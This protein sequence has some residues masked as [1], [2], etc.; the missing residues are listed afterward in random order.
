MNFFSKINADY[1]ITLFFLL[2]TANANILSSSTVGWFAIMGMMFIVAISRKQ[3]TRQDFANIAIFSVVYLA[4][5]FFRFFAVNELETDYLTSDV[6]FLFKYVFLAFIVT[7]LLKERALANIVRVTTHLTVLSFVFFLFQVLAGETMFRLFSA[8]NFPT[9]NDIPGYTNVLFFTYT[10]G[11]HDFSNS[12]FV[13]EPGSFGCFLVITL[14]FHFFLNRFRIDN[15]AI[16]LIIGNITTFSTTNYLGLLVLFFLAY[17]YRVPKINLWVL[18]LIPVSVLL[19]IFIPFLGDKIVETYQEDMRDLNHLKVLER[20]YRHNR[21]QIPLNRFSS[22]WHIYETFGNKL[23][24]GVS[25]KYNDILNKS[26]TV[27][28]SNGIFD[29]LAKFGLVGFIYL[30]YRYVRFCK[31]YVLRVENV[32]YCVLIILVTSFGE[33]ILILPFILM[34]MFLKAEQLPFVKAKKGIPNAGLK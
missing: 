3:F 11:F 19:F 20:F 21:M 12:G 32:L 22:M 30:L 33:P 8:I 18:I 29:F 16:I 34:F 15:T 24:L 27:N 10:K 13:W 2:L 25:N 9:G 14:M 7:V 23:I 26:Y 1:I 6:I 5:I 28:I 17:R 31:P 4:F